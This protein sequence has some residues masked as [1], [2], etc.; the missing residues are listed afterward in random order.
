MIELEPR[1][2]VLIYY[3]FSIVQEKDKTLREISDRTAVK[4]DVRYK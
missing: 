4:N 3:A 2:F 1:R